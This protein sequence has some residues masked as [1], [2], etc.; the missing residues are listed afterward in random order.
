MYLRLSWSLLFAM[1][2][3]C[4]ILG[5]SPLLPPNNGALCAGQF[6][7][8]LQQTLGSGQNTPSQPQKSYLGKTHPVNQ[9]SCLGK[10]PSQPRK[11]CL[12]KTHPVN[13]KSHIWVNHTQSTMK[14]ISGQNTSNQP[15]KLYLSKT[16]PKGT[17]GQMTPSQPQKS[18]T[19]STTKVKSRQ[20]APS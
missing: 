3:L 10:T 6:R 7:F 15:Q 4:G 17:Y 9:E 11:S 5:P 14:V 19:Q 13:H 20:Y 2:R 8:S 12:G 1:P 16:H 18:F